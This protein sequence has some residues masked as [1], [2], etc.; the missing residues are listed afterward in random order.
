MP[1]RSGR[2]EKR[3]RLTVPVEISNPQDAA[4]AE[5]TTTENGSALGIRVLAQHARAPNERLMIRSL[6]GELRAIVRVVYCQRLPDGNQN[7]TSGGLLC[8]GSRRNGSQP[9]RFICYVGDRHRV[10]IPTVCV[11]F[12]VHGRRGHPGH[13]ISRIPIYL[14]AQVVGILI[15]PAFQGLAKFST[16][17][18]ILG[19]QF[20]DRRR[21]KKQ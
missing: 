10:V 17:W 11:Q 7:G 12:A 15:L 3:T 4:G 16:L 8:R 9:F 14:A 18:T 21:A 1:T 6:E 5:R 2:L 13:A 19:K 20:P